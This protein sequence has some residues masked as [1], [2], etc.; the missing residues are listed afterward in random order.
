MQPSFFFN[1]FNLNNYCLIEIFTIQ[2]IS[3]DFL[4]QDWIGWEAK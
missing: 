2:E 3:F 4:P 1:G